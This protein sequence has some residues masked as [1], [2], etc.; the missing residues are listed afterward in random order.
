LQHRS[1]INRN[2]LLIKTFK[3]N[4][5]F[6]CYKFYLKFIQVKD[7][8]S[9]LLVKDPKKR[10][11]AGQAY[12]HPWVKR[13][14]DEES[15]NLQIDGDVFENI[16]RI[17]EAQSLKRTIFLYIATQIPEDEIK[18]LKNVSLK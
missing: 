17:L 14:V 8:I 4:Y 6:I 2:T 16:G 13:Q 7:L 5:L 1:K 9:K 10:F 11:T 3:K 12:E 18:N 15:K